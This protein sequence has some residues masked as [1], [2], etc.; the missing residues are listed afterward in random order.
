MYTDG[1]KAL[2]EMFECYWFLDII[3]SHQPQLRDEEFQLWSLGKNKDNSAMVICTDGID[4]ILKTLKI[5][6]TDFPCDEGT[7]WVELGVALLPSEH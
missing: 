5:K 7:V 1:V 6:Y 2:C 3:V 4:R